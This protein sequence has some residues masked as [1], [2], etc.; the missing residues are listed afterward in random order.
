MKKFLSLFIIA[1]LITITGCTNE[2][3]ELY[4]KLNQISN[5]DAF[6]LNSSGKM[7]LN[8]K[9]SVSTEV[10]TLIIDY[11]LNGYMDIR[12]SKGYIELSMDEIDNGTK[13]ELIPNLK[14]FI[15][16]DNMYYK[17]GEKYVCVEGSDTYSQ[18]S[19]K[20]YEDLANVLSI[21]VPVT[22]IANVYSIEMNE[23]EFIDQF[24]NILDN[25]IINLDKLN[26]MLD[27]EF[28]DE[29]IEYLQSYYNA[30]NV[31]I[32][33]GMLKPQIKNSKIK[34]DYEF[35]GNEKINQTTLVNIP[36]TTPI[37][38]ESLKLSVEYNSSSSLNKAEFKQITIP[39]TPYKIT[40]DRFYDMLFLYHDLD[41]PEFY[42]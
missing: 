19:K 17:S 27:L 28:T 10:E 26:S 22:K 16:K 41:L 36:I 9:S 42:E 3:A 34:L 7:T 15:D 24:I 31:S 6:D 4:S 13:Y 40:Q 30:E 5:W 8:L 39:Q 1:L 2:Q 32:Y 33:G 37:G 29:E 35:I 11:K 38:M 18:Y 25:M 14:M 23:N 12:N 20:V 21:D